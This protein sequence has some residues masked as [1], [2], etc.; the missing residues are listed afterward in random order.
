MSMRL[1]RQELHALVWERPITKLATEFGLSD[2]A[3][4]KI[5]RKFLV[6]TPPVG[7][8]AKKAHGK[9]ITVTPLPDLEDRSEILIRES[10][11]SNEPES[12][13]DARTAI[14]AVLSVSAEGTAPDSFVERTLLKI[15]R[16]KPGRD[17][18][19][20]S[21]GSSFVRMAVQLDSLE[22]AT[23][24]LEK[25]VSEGERAGISLTKSDEGVAW[26]CNGETVGFEL[27]EAADQVEHVA[28]ENELAAVA[29]W[30][31]ER[32]NYHRRYGYWKD[33][34]EPKIPKW[35][36]R[37]QGRLAVKLE[38]VRIKSDR[39]YWRGEPMRRTFAETRTRDLTRSIP[40]ILATIAAMAAAKRHNREF[41][42]RRRAAEAVVAR[43]RA[44]AE[45]RRELEAKAVVLLEQRLDEKAQLERLRAF[46]MSREEARHMLPERTKRLLD[47]A[48]ARRATF[49]AKLDPVGLEQRLVAAG[50]FE[51]EA[52]EQ[53][54]EI[55]H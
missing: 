21:E 37:Y 25:L 49:E 42:D 41:D 38:D 16:A 30:Q 19:V 17:G 54:A 28:T 51:D 2:V 18:L 7:F 32:E 55:C 23:I 20:R 45:R 50:L 4:H 10:T 8:W 14:L 39:S 53:T 3:L 27:V 11:A 35:E 46:L 24:T 43:Q 47:W 48:E 34:G 9:K 22:R 40:A 29:K 12:I 44:E 15:R 1:T 26:L 33:W 52:E 13:A 31:R 5:C 36:Q 6:P